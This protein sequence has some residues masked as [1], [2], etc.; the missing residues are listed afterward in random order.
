MPTQV[1]ICNQPVAWT[2]LVGCIGL[3]VALFIVIRNYTYIKNVDPFYML[4]FIFLGI[5]ALGVHS[6]VHLG[7]ETNYGYSWSKMIECLKLNK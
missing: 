1:D 6:T 5:I 2:H 4:C 3:L 7:M